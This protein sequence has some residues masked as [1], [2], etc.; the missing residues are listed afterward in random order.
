MT[1]L[2]PDCW[3]LALAAVMAI[4]ASYVTLTLALRVSTDSS[5]GWG[6]R[7]LCNSLVLGFGFWVANYVELLS[8]WPPSWPSVGLYGLIVPFVV[9]AASHGCALLFLARREPEPSGIVGSAFALAA[10]IG[11]IHG[12]TLDELPG[13][14]AMHGEA[15]SVC[16]AFVFA[17]AV[18]STAIWVWFRL[19]YGRSW[20]TSAAR[21][22]VVLAGAIAILGTNALVLINSSRAIGSCCQHPWLTGRLLAGGATAAG[23]AVLAVAL[24]IAIYSAKLNQRASCHARDLAEVHARLQYLATHD[25]LTGLP[26][27]HRFND[28]V[29]ES[30]RDSKPRGRAVAIAVLDIDRFSAINHSLGRGV[31]DWMLT[32]LSRRIRAAI[33]N[34]DTLARLG[35]DEFAI[36]I[37]N[38]A[39]RM[40]AQ[41]VTAAV[42]S[43]FEPPFVVNGIEVQV[44]PSIGASVW[45]DDGQRGD[46]LL[47]HAEAA[48]TVAKERGGGEV[49]FFQPGMT[50]S[51]QERLALENDLRR[52]VS[53]GEFEIYY[54]PEICTRTG[55]IASA[56]ALLR[57]R[58]PTKGLIGPSS[59]ISLAEETG[60]MIPLGEWVLRQVCRQAR[61]WQNELGCAV[62]LAVNLSATQFRHQNLLQV[63]RS[64]LDDSGL[65]ASAL[66]I[67]LT[68]SALMPNAEEA[69]GVLKQ[70]RKLGVC[71]A[72]D[73]FGT[74]YSSLSYLRR[75]PIDKLKIDRSFIRDLTTSTTDES[76]VRAIVSLARGVGLQVVAEGIETAEQLEFVTTLGCD[77]WQGYLC[78]TPQSAALLEDM[79]RNRAAPG[80]GLVAAHSRG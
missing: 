18:F 49:L 41:S 78:C 24:V 56:E 38:V 43:S 2:S 52:A 11:A 62:P 67:E 57:W 25:P 59:F 15:R 35:G 14:M 53:A 68:E 50:D 77:Q 79:L 23:C 65:A 45:P 39:G 76:I 66:E 34:A 54:Q 33:P 5:R 72:I 64:A 58:H 73:D 46:D 71:V 28:R 10:G 26:N 29:A 80:A 8:I 32:E 48:M 12:A 13:H 6:C 31:G 69:A 63:I 4:L 47:A 27:R 3:T 60:L 40:E 7:V 61:A 36:L 42:L 9:A 75:F 1:V 30:L 74:G 44:R 20:Q 19:R 51:M 55:R 17:F 22:A 70:L 37:N 16:T 21:I